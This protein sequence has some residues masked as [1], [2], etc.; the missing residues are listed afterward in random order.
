MRLYTVGHS[1]RPAETLLRLLRRHGIRRLADIRRVPRSRRHPQFDGEALG[2][3]L[4]REGIVYRHF[5]AL[6]GWR[7]PRPD[8]PNTAW[9]QP[10]F[11]GYAD[12]MLDAAF[13]AALEQ[14]LGFAGDEPTALM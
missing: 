13:E 12:Y 5:A 7:R 8:S 14:L 2:P 10:G 6:G 1:T 4:Q 9:R 11:R 3:L